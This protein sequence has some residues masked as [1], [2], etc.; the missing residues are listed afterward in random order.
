METDL[1]AALEFF[2]R[3]Q[4]TQLDVWSSMLLPDL[5]WLEAIK[6]SRALKAYVEGRPHSVVEVLIRPRKPDEAWLI[7]QGAREVGARTVFAAQTAAS[8]EGPVVLLYTDG[9]LKIGEGIRERFCLAEVDGAWMIV[10]RDVRSDGAWRRAGGR[11]TSSYRS[12]GE[13]LRLVDPPDE[14]SRA[15]LEA[16]S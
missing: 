16:L 11:S 5:S 1:T 13:L 7:T 15:I 9:F 12:L 4:E 6:R 14:D 10:R 3:F 8:S 2:Q